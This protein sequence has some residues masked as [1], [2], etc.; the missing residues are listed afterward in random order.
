MSDI[1]EP[2]DQHT[3]AAPARPADPSLRDWLLLGVL[4]LIGGASFA[5]IKLAVATALPGTVSAG[6]LWAAALFLLAYAYA[7]GRRLPAFIRR[8]EGSGKGWTVSTEWRFMMAGGVIGYAIPFTLFPFAQQTVSSMLAGI[9]MAF[10]PLVT[11]I[12]ARIFADEELTVRKVTG[13]VLGTTGVI[14]LIGPAAIA[15]ILSA[16]VIAQG[17]MILAVVCYAIYAVLTRRAP[18]MQA[19]SFAA[20]VMLSSAVAATPFALVSGQDWSAVSALSWL[21]ILFLGLFP[22]AIA[23]ILIITLIRKA[24]A[25]FMALTN[26]ATPVVAIIIG[27]S[28]FGEPLKPTFIAGLVAILIGLAIARTKQ[29]TFGAR[30]LQRLIRPRR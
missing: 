1:A 22:S 9:Y 2:T 20:G 25:G 28:A 15:N 12:L 7:T 4:T 27:M 10:M 8:Q 6:R 3:P 17:A 29:I 18:E 11:I 14:F 24:G 19:R 16:D 13:F 21:A 26:Y 5:G 30:G 23:A